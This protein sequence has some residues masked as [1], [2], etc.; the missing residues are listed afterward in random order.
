MEKYEMFF[1]TLSMLKLKYPNP[2]IFS[3]CIFNILLSLNYKTNIYK[4]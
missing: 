4:F 3:I 2:I 1:V